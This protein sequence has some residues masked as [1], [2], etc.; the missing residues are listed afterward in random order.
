VRCARSPSHCPRWSA[1][2]RRA[3]ARGAAGPTAGAGPLQRRSARASSPPRQRR[4]RAP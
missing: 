3:G 1:S 4:R 2:A